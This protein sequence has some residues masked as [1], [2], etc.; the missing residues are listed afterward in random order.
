MS[1]KI[2]SKDS[3][4]K[5]R[6]GILK[7]KSGS[8]ETPFFMPVATKTAVK[9]ISVEDLESM[10]AKAIISNAFIL[11]LQPGQEIIKKFKGIGNFMNFPGIVF[12]DSGGFQMYSQSLY[13]GSNEHGINFRNPFS[14]EKIFM[15]P[16]KNMQIQL[17]LGSDVAMC[18]DS[19]P[20]IE[21]SKNAISNAVRKT[22]NW[23]KICKLSHDKMQKNKKNKQLLFGIIQGGIHNDL[24]ERSAKELLSLD[25][26]GYSIGGLALGE[27][28]EQEYEMI[29]IVKS[30]LPEDKPVYLMGAGDALEILEA[31]SRGIDIFDSRFPTQNA[32]R[33]SLFTKKGRITITNSKYKEDS[34][35]I[36]KNCKCFVCQNHSKAYIRHLLIQEEGLGLRLA[37]YHNLFFLQELIRDAK[38]AIRENK[39]RSFLESFKKSYESRL[40]NEIKK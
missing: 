5:A 29:D 8:I 34:S 20:L 15:T 38:K 10:G 31:I 14:G 40:N 21:E 2:T 37:S 6:T 13:L 7:T 9:H 23:A 19:M 33:G 17:A 18:L 39:F 4:T 1:F 27:T 28:K 25:F 30:I 36:D 12:T 11:S 32:R 24:R 35:P 3:S 26:P 22:Y 16:E